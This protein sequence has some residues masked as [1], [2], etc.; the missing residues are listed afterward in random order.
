MAFMRSGSKVQSKINAIVYGAQWSGKSTY[1]AS[2]AKLKRPDGKPFRVLICDAEMGSADEVVT[3]LAD[4]GVQEDNILLIYSQS[5][6]EI[7]YYIDLAA[8]REDI[9]ILDD[10]GNPTN[11][12]VL[13][14]DGQPFHADALVIDGSTVIK[15]AC[16]Q[17]LLNMSRKRA[18]VRANKN[19]L[20]GDEKSVAIDSASLEMKDWGNLSYSGQSLILNL[21]ASGLNWIV[22]CREKEKKDTKMV[23]GTIQSVSTGIYEPDSFSGILYN[24]KTVLR[25]TRDEDEPDIVK[26][27]VEKDRTGTYSTGQ[28][29]ENPQIEDWQPLISNKV[30]KDFTPRNTMEQAIDIETRMYEKQAGIVDDGPEQSLH[31]SSIDPK[32]IKAQIKEINTKLY[33][34]QKKE[35]GNRLKSADLPTQISKIEDTSILTRILEIAKEVSEEK[36][37]N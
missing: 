37:S 30:G 15:M 23:N 36:I 19:N 7:N 8:K 6:N 20:V 2:M 9:P 13:D 22:T 16:Q 12:I 28:V 4:E 26:M 32:E 18:K 27:I 10:E 17:S 3:K 21:C 5:L 11:D 35:F 14:A 1:A 24:S 34:D 33:P 31:E 25:F 29:I